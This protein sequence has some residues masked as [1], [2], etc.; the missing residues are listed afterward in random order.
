MTESLALDSR[1]INLASWEPKDL[2][3]ETVAIAKRKTN[4]KRL[5]LLHKKMM[6]PIKSLI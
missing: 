6:I 3:T 4:A 2:R 5:T 1:K